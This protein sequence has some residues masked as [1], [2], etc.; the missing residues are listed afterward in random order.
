MSAGSSFA[1]NRIAAQLW[2]ARLDLLQ[3]GS[4]LVL[5][6]FMW[7]HMFLV[8]SILVSETAMYRVAKMF[9]G[10]YFFGRSYPW[11]VSSVVAVIFALLMLHAA[12]AL[13]KFPH[14][15]GQFF[16]FRAHKLRM[17]HGD[18][19]LWW[20]QVVTGFLLFFLA[21]MHLFGMFSQP[22]Q[23]GPYASSWRVY[24]T[25]WPLYLVLLFVVEL[26][27]AIG[28]YR[29][30]VKWVSFPQASTRTWRTRLTVLK[31]GLSVFFIALGLAT[32]VAYYQIGASLRDHPTRV[33]EPRSAVAEIRQ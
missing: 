19:T 17:H 31:W 28:L 2:S 1:S 32:L 9:E 4:G 22:D 10:Y 20:W 21:P 18:T 6:L 7:V 14:D 24:S 5:V 29:L 11:L 13:R 12:L 15:S 26:H 27:G 33:F 3:S 16:R 23:I 30:V 25:H 8:S